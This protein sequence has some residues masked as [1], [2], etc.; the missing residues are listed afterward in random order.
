MAQHQGRQRGDHSTQCKCSTPSYFRSPDFKKLPGELGRAYHNLV[1]YQ[2]QGTPYLKRRVSRDVFFVQFRHLGKRCRDF[3][4][5]RRNLID[6]LWPLLISKL[7]LA[8]GLVTV[9]LSALAKALSPVDAHGNPIPEQAVTPSRISRLVD[10]LVKY[11]LLELQALGWDSKRQMF[12]PKYVSLTEQGW[13]LTRCNIEKL[14]REQQ[15]RLLDVAGQS[16]PKTQFQARKEWLAKKRVSVL[17]QRNLA[18]SA[19]KHAARLIPLSLEERKHAVARW[20]SKKIAF[21]Q[22]ISGN[23]LALIWQE[24]RRKGLA[25]SSPPDKH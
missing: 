3:R 7:D 23:F 24:L 15:Q 4:P 20:L 17:I 19:G 10:T 2:P 5:E 25:S 1:G 8:T 6:A 16:P 13:K 18:I 9:C 21:K 14:Y 12:L 11:G 22:R